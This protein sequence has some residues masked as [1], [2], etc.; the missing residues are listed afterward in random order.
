LKQSAN[1]IQICS[2]KTKEET[3]VNLFVEDVSRTHDLVQAAAQPYEEDTQMKDVP[4]AMGADGEYKLVMKDLQFGKHS[5]LIGVLGSDS[6]TSLDSFEMIEKVDDS[7]RFTVSYHFESAI[8]TDGTLSPADR[9]KRLAQELA[10]LKNSLPLSFSSSV[11]V[12]YDSSR[13]DVL[14]FLIT[15][16]AGT[17]YENGC[18]VFHAYFTVAYP[19]VAPEVFLETTGQRTVRFNPNLYECGRVCLSLLNTWPGR[20]EEMWNAKTSTFLQVLVS[21]Q[22]LI[23]ID[24]PYFNEP[25]YEGFRGT[26]KGIK[27]SNEYNQG[28]Y[29]ETIQWAIIDQ[30]RNPTP[31]FKDV[32]QKHFQLKRNDILK[33]VDKWTEEV[34]G[35]AELKESLVLELA[36]LPKEAARISANVDEE[37]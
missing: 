27:A 22:S 11:F 16:P 3:E 7:F 5:V 4:D 6:R 14:K 35:L 8:R 19:Y 15:G 31:C 37:K 25:G 32:I 33:Q 28:L 26:P 13:M 17:P 23:F 24:E 30:M 18:F 1:E 21:I 20:P 29:P 9:I 34:P 12:R 10:T 36:K 2:G